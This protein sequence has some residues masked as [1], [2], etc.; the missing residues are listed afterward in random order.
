MYLSAAGLAEMA[1]PSRIWWHKVE[2]LQPK[3]REKMMLILE[4]NIMCV[5]C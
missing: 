2:I 1:I 3:K 4:A 5:Y